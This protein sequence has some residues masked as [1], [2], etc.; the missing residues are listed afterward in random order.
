MEYFTLKNIAEAFF[1]GKTVAQCTPLTSGLI[2]ETWRLD[3]ADSE[4]AFLVQKINTRIFPD[5]RGLMQNHAAV[6]AHLQKKSDFSLFVPIP[7]ATPQGDYCVDDWRVMPFLKNTYTPAHLPT[8]EEAYEAARAYGLFLRALADLPMAD[9]H[10]PLPGFHNTTRRYERFE[11]AVN[12]DPLGRCREVNPEIHQLQ[13]AR[14]YYRL[15][16]S[17]LE[18]NILPQ[19]AVHNDTKAGNV[20]LYQG[21]GKAAAVIDWDTIMPGTPLSDYGDMV[22]TFVSNCYEDAPFGELALRK[23]VWDALDTGFLAAT[24]DFLSDVE[25]YLL[26]FGA[27][28]IVG[29]Q[30]LR[31]LT[32]YIEGDV[33]YKTDYPTHNLVRAR[34]Q[35]ALLR[36]LRAFYRL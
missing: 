25:R 26:P 20:L 29:E 21:T 19:Y 1:P 6:A 14:M 12:R 5:A 32:D 7:V 9:W 11:A 2:N 28:W 16:E 34:N 18:K 30:A 15:V 35:L 17:L 24:A 27:L 3:L 4:G 33:Y 8:A 31:F 22:R 36:E 23:D 10:H 13:A